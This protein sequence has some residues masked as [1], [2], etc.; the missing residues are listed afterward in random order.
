M[1]DSLSHG[2]CA[3]ASHGHVF[4]CVMQVC[5]AAASKAMWQLRG[6]RLVQLRYGCFL[7]V[8][9]IEKTTYTNWAFPCKGIT[10]KRSPREHQSPRASCRAP[11]FRSMDLSFGC[12]CA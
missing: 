6:G 3:A 8:C 4:H 10:C 11:S 5:H 7:Q 12:T 1:S 2:G 9:Q